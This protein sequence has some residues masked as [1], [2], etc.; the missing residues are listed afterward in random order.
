VL[1]RQNPGRVKHLH[2]TWARRVSRS[3]APLGFIASIPGCWRKVN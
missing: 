2:Q 1:Q 3:S